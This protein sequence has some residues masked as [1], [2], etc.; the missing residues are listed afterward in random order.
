VSESFQHS[1]ARFVMAR[2]DAVG[3][4]AATAM[5]LETCQSTKKTETTSPAKIKLLTQLFYIRYGFTPY[6]LSC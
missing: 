2:K 4:Y 5:G 1:P 3:K 6:T